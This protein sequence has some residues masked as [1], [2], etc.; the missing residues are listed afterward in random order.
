M[1]PTL[2]RVG[3]HL[4]PL[5]MADAPAWF[6][7]LS[8]PGAVEHTSWSLDGIEVLY[9]QIA[10]SHPFRGDAPVLFAIVDDLDELVGTVGFH[11]VFDDPRGGEIAYN[12]H[13]AHWGRG[14]ASEACAAV[15]QW[16]LH[17]RGYARVDAY[18]LD[19]NSASQRV[20][21]KCG[22]RRVRLETGLRSVRGAPRDFWLY[23]REA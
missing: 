5:V 22:F 21:D 4:R 19:S 13:P 9:P 2:A 3:L 14:I 10:A 11:T 15:T 12:L 6:A 18:A 16:G 8:L 7:Y 23:R 20:L 1:M 17:E